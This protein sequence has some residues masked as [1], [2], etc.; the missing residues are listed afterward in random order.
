[1]YSSADNGKSWAEADPGTSYL[2][3][4]SVAIDPN[5][6]T[7]MFMYGVDG[8][9][10]SRSTDAGATWKQSYSGTASYGVVVIDPGNSQHI[11]ANSYPTPVVSNDGGTTWQPITFFGNTIVTTINFDPNT[12]STIYA[13]VAAT[14]GSGFIPG[15]AKSVD[16]GNTWTPIHNGLPSTPSSN[17]VVWAFAISPDSKELLVSAQSGDTGGL[18]RSTDGGASWSQVLGETPFSIAFD[19]NQTGAVYASGESDAVK[20][21][22]GGVTWSQLQEPS[23]WASGG[24]S[25]PINVV[26]DPKFAGQVFMIPFYGPVAWSPDHGSDW[27]LLSNGLSS[28]TYLSNTFAT[29]AI[30]PTSP[31]VLY[32]PSSNRTL[33][34]LTLDH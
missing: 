5:Q 9:P 17:A 22:D 19:P 31:E 10:L 34:T 16:G 18:Y 23:G 28:E 12:P 26:V 20:S 14:S 1:M 8:F 29:P 33:V 32:I 2:F 7:T 25:G 15:V 27:Y 30:A 3:S 4:E 6:P 24:V 21:T 11:L 13:G